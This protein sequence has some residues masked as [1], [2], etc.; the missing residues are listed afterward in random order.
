MSFTNGG[1]VAIFP[2]KWIRECIAT[3]TKEH[4][5]APKVLV[6]AEDDYLDYCLNCSINDAKNLNVEVIRGSYLKVG[7]INLAMGV[8]DDKPRKKKQAKPRAARSS[9]KVGARKRSPS[10]TRR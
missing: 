2:G 10:S 8:K 7:E 5:K 6:V 1:S 3:Y 9:G 4:G